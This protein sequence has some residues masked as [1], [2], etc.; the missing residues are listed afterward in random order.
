[1][2]VQFVLY[3]GFDPIDVIAPYEVVVAGGEAA[4]STVEAVFVS[5]EG[6]R[7]VPSGHPAISLKAV[8]ALDPAAPGYI[9]VP[10]A[11]GPVKGDPD[12]GA[13]T[14]PV[15]LARAAQSDLGPLM[16]KALATAG[17][18]VAGVC[19]GSLVLAMAGL[20]ENR[21]AATHSMGMDVLEATGARVVRARVVREGD[22]ITCGGVTSGIDLTLHILEREYGPQVAHAVE[23]YM[24][25]ERRGIVWEETGVQ[26]VPF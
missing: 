21:A 1:M 7:T 10:G 6:P 13:V 4:G 18:T 23:T 11:I 16:E 8:A 14:I 15:L 25:H 3:D 12:A 9:V 5:A 17:V 22:L 24:E 19:G 26:P 2:L 20:L